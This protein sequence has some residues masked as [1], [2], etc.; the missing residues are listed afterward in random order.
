MSFMKAKDINEHITWKDIT[1]GCAIFEGASSE[2]VETGDWRTLK[3]SSTGTSASSAC[4]ARL[5]VPTCP[6]P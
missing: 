4:C 2:L 1:P 6:F 5:C 3:P